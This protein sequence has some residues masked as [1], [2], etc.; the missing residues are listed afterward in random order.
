MYSPPTCPV[1]LRLELG[2]PP[3]TPTAKIPI[4]VRTA[5]E[6]AGSQFRALISELAASERSTRR[7]FRD[8][9][10]GTGCVGVDERARVCYMPPAGPPPFHGLGIIGCVM[11]QI[12]ERATELNERSVIT[13][14]RGD[15]LAMRRR[16]RYTDQPDGYA[17][18]GV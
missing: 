7:R 11:A 1:V 5:T 12:A 9:C 8:L 6:A 13:V 18:R 17:I 10:I 14:V 4:N 15:N 2:R 3:V 16:I